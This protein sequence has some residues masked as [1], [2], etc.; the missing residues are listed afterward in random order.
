MGTLTKSP[1]YQSRGGGCPDSI[2]GV[3]QY[4]QWQRGG[5]AALLLPLLNV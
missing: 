1:S 3:E 2:D 5:E 4:S